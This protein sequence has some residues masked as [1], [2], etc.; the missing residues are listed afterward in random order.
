MPARGV[1]HTAAFKPTQTRL[2]SLT[3][4]GDRLM[5]LFAFCEQLIQD[6]R[7][8]LRMM[9]GQP[10][11]AAMAMLSLA[12]GI[13]ANTAIYSFMDAILVRSLPVRNPE[14][15][16][17]LQ[18]HAKGRPE[19]V[20]NINGSM[21]KDDQFG[22]VSPNLPWRAFEILSQDNPVLS[23]VVS[24]KSTYRITALIQ[25]QGAV[26]EGMHV[27]GGF[28]GAMGTPPAAGRLIGV[29]DDR[30]GAPPV[31]VVSYAF[32]QRRFGSAEQAVG[33]TATVNDTPFIIVGV[34]HPGF[35]GISPGQKY[36]I[37]LPM[38]ATLLIER[39]Y[40]GDPRRRYTEETYYWV[41]ILGRLKPGVTP[42]Q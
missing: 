2:F 23:Q 29:E 17:V 24:F 8:A 9:A 16:V 36:D 6:L 22:R 10:L 1:G 20:R 27:S 26:V 12:L 38:K 3:C 31:A 35:L 15:L 19:V 11:F 32:A 40:G 30:E 7:Y 13:G 42:A 37:Y 14:S 39:I 34:T 18:W 28:F 21:W 5:R 4:E 41:E 25:N 33:Q